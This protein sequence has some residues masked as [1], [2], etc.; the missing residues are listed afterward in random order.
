MLNFPTEDK[1]RV[2]K[3]ENH[4]FS[5]DDKIVTIYLEPTENPTETN[6]RLRNSSLTQVREKQRSDEKHLNEEYIPDT[7]ASCV[8]KV[9]T[10]VHLFLVL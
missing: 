7:V 8:Q 10:I 5:L 2:L 3:K 6:N 9:L 1:E 4:N